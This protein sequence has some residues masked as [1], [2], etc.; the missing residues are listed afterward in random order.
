ML[1]GNTENFAA[2]LPEIAAVKDVDI[3]T[4]TTI[5]ISVRKRGERNE[6]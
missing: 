3:V 4:Q 6:S 5:P 1:M 2:K